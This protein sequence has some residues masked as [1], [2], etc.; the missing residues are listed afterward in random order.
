MTAF[1]AHQVGSILKILTIPIIGVEVKQRKFYKL[2]VRN[3][4]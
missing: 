1:H 3:G 2:W 4:H